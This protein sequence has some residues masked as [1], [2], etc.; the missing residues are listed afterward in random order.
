MAIDMRLEDDRLPQSR[1]AILHHAMAVAI[2]NADRPSLGQILARRYQVL[3]VVD[4]EERPVLDR[5]IVDRM[6]ISGDKLLDLRARLGID[7]PRHGLPPLQ[8]DE[9]A[10][11]TPEAAYRGFGRAR[12]R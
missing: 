5:V 6:G 7:D 10:I 3:T 4:E 1:H 9:A 11:G 2:H 8:V 12:L